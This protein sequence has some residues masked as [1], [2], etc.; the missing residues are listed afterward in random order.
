MIMQWRST[1]GA[2]ACWFVRRDGIVLVRW[3][4]AGAPRVLAL[5]AADWDGLAA[6]AQERRAVAGPDGESICWGLSGSAAHRPTGYVTVAV[7]SP[8]GEQEIPES[9]W[10]Q[11]V[12]A[13]RA[14]VLP[15]TSPAGDHR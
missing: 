5:P 13:A 15:A 1:P 2:P 14:G 4:F 10:G 9:I 7:G 11:I 6:A 8:P 12:A 3:Q